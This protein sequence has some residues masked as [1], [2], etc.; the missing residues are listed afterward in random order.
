MKYIT[1][2]LFFTWSINNITA[3]CFP[4]RHSTNHD[5]GWLSCTTSANPNIAR[6][7]GHW[8]MYDLTFPYSLTELH[9]WNYNHPQFLNR[10]A[11]QIIIDVSNDG[12]NW[13]HVETVELPQANGRS[14][15]E[16][17]NIMNFNN[18]QARFVLI[19][20][21]TNWGGS[22]FGLAEVRIG[23]NS[24]L[25]CEPNLTLTADLTSRKYL[26][27]QSINISSEVI[28]GNVVLL[29][30]GQN[31]NINPGFTVSSMSEFQVDLSPCN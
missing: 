22:C 15:Y 9:L 21:Q 7:S 31:V 6:G 16:G 11:R 18:T 8:I 30:A 27:Q 14:T 17:V 20:V 24:T 10:G 1:A 13:T 19:T 28:G 3:Q 12:T 4:D 23:V 5:A 25:N 2:L 26:A 29:Q